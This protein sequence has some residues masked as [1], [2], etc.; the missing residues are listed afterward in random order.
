MQMKKIFLALTAAFAAAT[1]FSCGGNIDP[2]DNGGN[3]GGETNAGVY[4]ISVDKNQIEA[5]GKDA[6][7]FTLRDENGQ[8]ITAADPGGVYFKIVETGSFLPRRTR[9]YTAFKNETVTVAAS[10]NGVDAVNTVTITSVN[11]NKYETFHKNVAL[12]KCTGTAC[13]YCPSLTAAL[14]ALDDELKTHTVILACHSEL[15]GD[16]P[17]AIRYGSS[18]LG[19]ELLYQ[20]N[21][22]GGL[23]YLVINMNTSTG[24]RSVTNITNMINDQRRDYPATSGIKVSTAYENN[25]LHISATLKSSTGGAYNLG[26]AVLLD[27]QY[28]P[29]VGS[30]DGNYSNIVRAVTDNFMRYENSMEFTVGKD[31]EGTKTFDIAVSDLAQNK[32][33]CR[34]VVFSLR[35]LEGGASIVDNIVSCGID[36][37]VDYKYN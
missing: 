18:D 29:S 16:D 14:N 23:P 8:D 11:R 36:S 17:Y 4:T 28:Y 12:Y 24:D 30:S 2:D 22:S 33:D 1:M 21:E 25:N 37:S 15:I 31:A 6:A 3:N 5:D 26:C 20:F 10:Y 35:K 19:T 27:N 9:T 32:K 13:Q 34:V 7:T